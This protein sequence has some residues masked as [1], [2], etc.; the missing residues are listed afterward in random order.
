MSLPLAFD[1]LLETVPNRMPYIK[2]DA[3][4]KLQWHEKLKGI[5]KPKIGLVWSGGFRP[6][7]PELW[8]VNRR[9]N[10]QFAEISKI[11]SVNFHFIS[12]QKGAK[13]EEELRLHQNKLWANNNFSSFSD[14]INDFTDTAALISELDLVISVDTSTAHLV[15]ALGKPVWIL[16]RYDNCWRWLDSGRTS[17]WYPSAKLYR[18]DKHGDWETVIAE[19]K[20][21]LRNFSVEKNKDKTN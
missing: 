19:I 15:G 6:E 4:K 21:D 9:R 7:Q 8:G 14:E 12:L 1:T 2:V 16:N 18:Q 13:A 10:I 5:Q 11:Q 20:D 17:S 3:I